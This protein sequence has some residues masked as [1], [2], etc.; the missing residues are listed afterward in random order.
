MTQFL[1][2]PDRQLKQAAVAAPPI[3]RLRGFAPS[4]TEGLADIVD[5]HVMISSSPEA[6]PRPDQKLI[7]IDAD[8][9][10]SLNSLLD[11]M[12]AIHAKYGCPFE[13][14]QVYRCISASLMWIEQRRQ[15]GF[16]WTP[17][18]ALRLIAAD[19][20]NHLHRCLAEKDRHDPEP[21]KRS[22]GFWPD[23]PEMCL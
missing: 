21:P 2:H 4:S 7:R 19:L 23:L 14:D 5:S 15:L 17:G 10:R 1:S 9:L 8:L 16:H 12:A 3:R 18:Q 11:R 20:L 6:S 13:T 22:V